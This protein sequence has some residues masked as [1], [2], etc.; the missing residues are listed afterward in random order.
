VTGWLLIISLLVLG[1]LLATLGDLLG[2]RIGKARLSIFKLRPKKTAI[3]ITVLTGSLI[4]AI[5]LGLMLLVSR[6]LRVGLFELNDIQTRLSE[7]RKALLPLQKE[8]ILLEQRII[9]GEEELKQLESN[10]IALRRGD[11][12]ISSGQSLATMI[13][14][15]QDSNQIKEEIQNLLQRA[16]LY[17]YLKIRPGDNPDKRILLIKRNHIEKLEEFLSKEGSWV[18][19]IKSAGNVLLGE[20]YIYAYPEVILNRKIVNLD[21]VISSIDLN[22]NNI[23]SN[24]INDN[25]QILISSTLAEV[26]RRGSIS[27]ELQINA[28]DINNIAKNILNKKISEV[29]INAVS[30]RESYTADPVSI[31]LQI[32]EINSRTK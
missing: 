21:E 7:S 2:S 16:N 1:G 20:N 14:N 5:S 23:K 22:I 15:S 31:R 12:V 18:V 30:L 27:S 25:M 13:I 19:N 8:R 32:E 17:S 6:Q 9:N 11:V 10:L 4:S 24:D 29:K 3:F 28:N 26:K